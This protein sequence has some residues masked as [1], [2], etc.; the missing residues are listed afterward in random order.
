M[1]PINFS[2][3]SLCKF[4]AFVHILH[5]INMW[6]FANLCFYI[7]IIVCCILGVIIQYHYI[8]MYDLGKI[9]KFLINSSLLSSSLNLIKITSRYFGCE[10]GICNVV[11]NMK[12]KCDVASHSTVL[13]SGEAVSMWK[14]ATTHKPAAVSAAADDDDWDTDPDFVVSHEEQIIQ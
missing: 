4:A 9:L 2:L 7:F 11:L 1:F 8:E 10:V 13:Y 14:A 12:N 6:V 5:V 3:E